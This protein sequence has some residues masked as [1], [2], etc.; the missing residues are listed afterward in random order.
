MNNKT[1]EE[2]LIVAIWMITFNHENY[3]AQAVESVMMQKTNFRY[4][5]FIGEDFSADKTREICIAIMDKYPDKIELSLQSERTGGYKNAQ[6]LYKKC[7]ESG[8][9]YVAMCDGDDYWMDPLKLQKQVNFLVSNS[10]YSFVFTPSRIIYDL[11]EKPDRIRSKYSD[12][13]SDKFKLYDIL[14]L[15]GGFYPTSSLLFDSKILDPDG[16]FYELHLKCNAGDWILAIIASLNGRIGYMD[17]A[18]SVY[19]VH[20]NSLSNKLYDNFKECSKT[21]K[22]KYEMN[23]IF[24]DA[25]FTKVKMSNKVR[26]YLLKKEE[27]ILLSKY[28]DCGLGWKVIKHLSLKNTGLLFAVRLISKCCFVSVFRNSPIKIRKV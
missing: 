18:M 19:R 9:K 12:F 6:D 27:Y 16:L 8:A 21:A 7:Y 26:R 25:L 3:I 24:L 1:N 28:L 20:S 23:I 5:L 10:E 4:K 2:Q 13:N 14:K 15:G 17:E 22:L 11:G